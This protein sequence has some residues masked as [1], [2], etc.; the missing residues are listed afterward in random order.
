MRLSRESR[1]QA[2]T[3]LLMTMAMGLLLSGFLT[4]QAQGLGAGFIGAWGRRFAS[5]YVV[6]LPLV[7]ILAPVARMVAL[8]VERRLFP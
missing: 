7:T 2:L 6:I 5:S 8:R 1:Q 4:Y 3:L